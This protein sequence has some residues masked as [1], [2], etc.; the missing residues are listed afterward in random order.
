[1]FEKNGKGFF[2]EE[3]SLELKKFRK[4]QNWRRRRERGG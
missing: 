2:I 4:C 1:M 3:E